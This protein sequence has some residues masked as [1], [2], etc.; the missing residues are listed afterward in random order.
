[1]EARLGKRNPAASLSDE[2]LVEILSRLP[3][4]SVCRFKCVSRSWRRL[5][6]DPDHRKKLPQTLA[7]FF[8]QSLSGERFPCVAQ[9]FTNV[10]GKGVPFVYPSFSFLPV[11]GTD[12]I[13][14][15]CCN[16]LL[17]CR[18]YQPGPCDP[19]GMRPSCY[20]V[21]NP[22]TEKWVILPDSSRAI[23]EV[24]TARLCFDL[25]I[26]S[27]FHVV[28]YV[29][30]EDDYVTGV[31]IYSSRTSAWS[32][33]ESEWRDDLSLC[34]GSRSVFRNGFLHTVVLSDAIVALDMEGKSWRTIPT[35][36]CGEPGFISQAQGRLCFFSAAADDA[37][38]LSVWTL[39]DYGTD[40]WTLKHTVSSLRLF[41]QKNMR[42][43]W[44]YKVIAVHPECNLIF[45]L[46]GWDKTLMAYEM[47]RREV[48]IIRN[49][50]H[51]CWPPYLPYVPLFSDSLADGD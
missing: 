8:Y 16:G 25:A 46:Y 22:A 43:D 9:H 42:F 21:C 5:I 12:V 44:E 50:G 35:P 15:D 37:F 10:S 47:D 17:L 18:C 51:D 40:E 34:D 13:P 38:K 28:E 2:L 30:D 32:S 48:R 11:P 14:L 49:L 45:F 3:V 19:D 31:E 20:A 41:R 36:P 39:E 33:K 27:H 29:E 1:M 7:G 4:R 23:G 24:R 26:S 6:S